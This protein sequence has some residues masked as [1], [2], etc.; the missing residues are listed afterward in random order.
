MFC[1][2][3]MRLIIFIINMNFRKSAPLLCVTKPMSIRKK[4]NEKKLTTLGFM[5][6]LKPSQSPQK[7]MR[8]EKPRY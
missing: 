3:Y 5:S 4:Q 2:P 1:S 7:V 8:H 6:C